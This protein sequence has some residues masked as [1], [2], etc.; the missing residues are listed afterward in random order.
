MKNYLRYISFFKF[1]VY[2]KK[3]RELLYYNF[4]E[5]FNFKP[6]RMY[7]IYN[8]NS[9]TVRG[10]HAHKKTRQIFSCISGSVTMNFYNRS[11]LLKSI[12][13][14][15]KKNLSVITLKPVWLELS[16]FSSKCKLL[17]LADKKFSKKDYLFDKNK[18]N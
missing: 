1:S 16:N 15:E 14:N 18:V 9:K 11:G 8:S 3:N 4:F 2:K 7:F 13:L 17:I 5:K 6:V 12:K 10:R